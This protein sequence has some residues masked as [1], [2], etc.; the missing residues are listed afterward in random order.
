LTIFILYDIGT[1]YSPGDTL[2]PLLDYLRETNEASGVNIKLERKNVF[3]FD[4]EAFRYLMIVKDENI[5][6][7][8]RLNSDE[9]RQF[10]DSWTQ[11]RN[12]SLD[13][14]DYVDTLEPMKMSELVTFNASKK[15]NQDWALRTRE[16]IEKLLK[17]KIKINSTP[18]AVPAYSVSNKE[19]NK[20]QDLI[21]RGKMDLKF[22]LQD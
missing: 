5:P 3:C 9:V 22:V 17:L 10:R 2:E 12:A 4:N 1:N 21:S 13:L 16:T 19:K 7:N 14:I 11:S 15:T 18:K 6:D 8:F 20:K